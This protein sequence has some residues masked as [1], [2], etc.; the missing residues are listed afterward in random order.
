M[1]ISIYFYYKALKTISNLSGSNALRSYQKFIASCIFIIASIGVSVF[2][3]FT[4]MPNPNEAI[5]MQLKAQTYMN[6]SAYI[7]ML[8]LNFIL[9]FAWIKVEEINLNPA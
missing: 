5:L 8:G 1:I 7:V 9:L 2:I 3:F 4:Y 6:I